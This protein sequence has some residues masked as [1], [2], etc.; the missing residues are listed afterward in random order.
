MKEL[1]KI[2]VCIDDLSK[3]LKIGHQ[4]QPSTQSKIVNFLRQNLDIFAWDHEDMK[5]I[6]PTIACHR[7]HVYPTIRPRQKMPSVEPR[8]V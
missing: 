2:Q 1:E 7:L 8:Q 4:L 6:N 3:E 5:G